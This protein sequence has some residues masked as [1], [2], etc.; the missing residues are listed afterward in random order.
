M[1]DHLDWVE[2]V[3]HQ[4]TLQEKLNRYLAFVESGEILSSYPYAKERP[5]IFRVVTQHE[6]D[7]SGVEFLGRAGKVIE[8][9]GFRFQY[10]LGKQPG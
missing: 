3:L 4:L 10:T 8:N 7:P 1:S 5:V 6:P 2:S 9:A